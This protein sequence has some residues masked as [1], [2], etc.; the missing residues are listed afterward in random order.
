MSL[1]RNGSI[2]LWYLWPHAWVTGK[3]NCI[4]SISSPAVV[5][6]YGQKRLKEETVY[7]GSKFKGAVHGREREAVGVQSS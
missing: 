1:K 4:V 5:I 7:S 2:H 3:K 6:K